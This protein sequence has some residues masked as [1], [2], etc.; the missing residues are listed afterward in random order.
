MLSFFK[1]DLKRAFTEPTFF[2]ALILGTVSLIGA[3][4]YLNISAESGFLMAQS[5]V[6]PFAAPFLAALPFAAME[7]NERDINYSDLLKLRRGGRGYSGIRFFTVG[8][9]GGASLLLPELLLFVVTAFS[10]GELSGLGLSQITKVLLLSFPTGFAFAVCAYAITFFC[11]LSV[12]ALIT[13]EVLYLLLTYAFPYLHLEKYYP[14]L[15]VSPYI[16]GEPDFTYIIVFIC[17]VILLSG[18]FVSAA[19][20]AEKG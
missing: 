10:N 9:V 14:P 5:L 20:I 6:F 17:A 8:I 16:Y 19:K 11:R 4:I 13:P 15:A 7:K 3:F 12:I 18:L 1:T 2:T